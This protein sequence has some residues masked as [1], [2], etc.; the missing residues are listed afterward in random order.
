MLKSFVR[1]GTTTKMNMNS[2]MKRKKLENLNHLEIHSTM[3]ITIMNIKSLQ[4]ND[5]NK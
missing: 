2:F 4:E 1:L 5:I 3:M